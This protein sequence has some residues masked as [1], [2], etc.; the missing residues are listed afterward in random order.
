MIRAGQKRNKVSVPAWYRRFLTGPS[1][2]YSID[3]GINNAW[4]YISTPQY[5]FMA[6]YLKNGLG[7]QYMYVRANKICNIAKSTFG[8]R[9]SSLGYIF[10]LLF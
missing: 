6:W 8:K 2:L 7:L 9:T 3:I 4:S 10:M 1:S 5:V